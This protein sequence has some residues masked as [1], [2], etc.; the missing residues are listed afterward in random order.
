MLALFIEEDADDEDLIMAIEDFVSMTEETTQWG[1]FPE[2]VTAQVDQQRD[3]GML[4]ILRGLL[5]CVDQRRTPEL[6]FTAIAA[7][8]DLITRQSQSTL[9]MVSAKLGVEVGMLPIMCKA[10]SETRSRPVLQI[11]SLAANRAPVQMLPT[12][13]KEGVVEICKEI[14]LD[15]GSSFASPFSVGLASRPVQAFSTTRRKSR[16]LQHCE[17]GGRRHPV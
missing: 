1:Q 10:L 6:R 7:L 9:T 16:H 2:D 5:Q 14:I 17:D 11:L 8:E 4:A 15:S 13:V 3:K 12:I